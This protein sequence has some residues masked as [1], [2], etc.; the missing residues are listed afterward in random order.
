MKEGI[1]RIIQND[2]AGIDTRSGIRPFR[3]LYGM[4]VPAQVIV[5]FKECNFMV[6]LQLESGNDPGDTTADNGNPLRARVDVGAS[7]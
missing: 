7:H 2:K 6:S 5:R 1:R 3:D 4:G